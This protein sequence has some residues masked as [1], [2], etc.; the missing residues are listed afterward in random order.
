M[1]KP[2]WE[3]AITDGPCGDLPEPYQKHW[4]SIDSGIAHV[5]FASDEDYDNAFGRELTDDDFD[6]ISE[7]DWQRQ[8][9]GYSN[10]LL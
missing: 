10:S 9:K 7:F 6:R 1:S 8:K 2:T 4:D 5:F 3:Q